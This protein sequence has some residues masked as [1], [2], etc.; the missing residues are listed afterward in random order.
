MMWWDY[1]IRAEEPISYFINREATDIVTQLH[2][3]RQCEERPIIFVC[4]GLGG[5]V[6]KKVSGL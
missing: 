1:D 2:K 6:L 3:T 5:M 4:V